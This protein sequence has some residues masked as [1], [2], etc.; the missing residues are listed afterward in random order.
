MGHPVKTLMYLN[1]IVI[2]VCAFS[3]IQVRA[4]RSVLLHPGFLRFIWFRFVLGIAEMQ[5]PM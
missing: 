5:L 3:I 1:M 2:V 4:T